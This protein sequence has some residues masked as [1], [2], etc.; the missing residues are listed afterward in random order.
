MTNNAEQM[1]TTNNNALVSLK[2][3]VNDKQEQTVSGRALHEFLEVKTRYNDWFKRMT[4]YGF[5]ENVD[6]FPFTQKRVSGNASGIQ[7]LQDHKL[8]INMAK[9]LCMLARS[10]RGKKARQYFIQCEKAWNEP[11]AVMARALQM[12][13]RVLAETQEKMNKYITE[14]QP[15]IDFANAVTASKDCIY[16]RELAKILQQNGY[17]TGEK[18][19]Y[20]WLRDNGYL[21]KDRRD[22]DYNQPTQ[23]AQQLKIFKVNKTVYE[24][25]LG[26]MTSTTTLVTPKGQ[27]YFIGKF[28]EKFIPKN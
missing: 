12:S 21:I 13:Q 19:L 20:K 1:M 18:R 11:Q 26:E 8:T 6:Y 23:R 14:N 16:I 9:E 5:T 28:K 3:E 4:E 15:K 7:V 2:I 10:E 25:S 27:Q 24:T 22:R 17:N